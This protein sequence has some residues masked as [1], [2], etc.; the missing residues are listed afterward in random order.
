MNVA[1]IVFRSFF[2]N[3]VEYARFKLEHSLS[4]SRG[5]RL[6]PEASFVSVQVPVP[7]YPATVKH[8]PGGVYCGEATKAWTIEVTWV[9]HDGKRLYER[10]YQ[11]GTV[12]RQFRGD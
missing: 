10:R 1:E 2:A 6:D 11:D 7:D 12:I 4:I 5:E 3:E 9:T 8:M